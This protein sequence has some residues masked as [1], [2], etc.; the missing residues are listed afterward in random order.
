MSSVKHES[1]LD[2]LRRI[3]L[4]DENKTVQELKERVSSPEIRS[5]DVAEILPDALSRIT[6]E[7]RKKDLGRALSEPLEEAVKLSI[8]K[9]P[10]TFADLLY[11]VILPAIR[12][13]VSEMLRS[14][15]ERIDRAVSQRF[16]LQSLKWRLE[17]FRTGV[18]FSEILL[19]N[20]TIYSVEQA[21]LIHK[22]SGLL[23]QHSYTDDARH[24]DSDAVSGM[25]I[26]IERFV[27]DSFVENDEMLQR[28]TIGEHMV[29]LVDGPHAMLACVVRGMP[30]ASFVEDMREVLE[31]MHALEHDALKNFSGDKS[32]LDSLQP[33][34]EK[35]LHVEYKEQGGKDGQKYKRII[36]ATTA[37]LVLATLSGMGYWLFNKIQRNQVEAYV[38]GLNQQPGI[39]V[40]NYRKSGGEWWLE[41]LMDPSANRIEPVERSFFLDP[42]KVHLSLSAF[43]GMDNDVIL[44]RAREAL[45]VPESLQVTFDNGILSVSGNAPAHW[46]LNARNVQVLPPGVKHL[47]LSETI[48]EA[49]EVMAFLRQVLEPPESVTVSLF[50]NKI[51]YQG[52][53]SLDWIKSLHSLA[54]N[55]LGKISFDSASLISHEQ[56]RLVTLLNALNNRSIDFIDGTQL[57]QDAETELPGIAMTILE[58]DKLASM[59]GRTWQLR[60]VGQADDSGSEKINVPLRLKRAQTVREKLRRYGVPMNNIVTATHDQPAQKQVRFE[61]SL[62]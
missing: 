31:Q 51:Q 5:R 29:Y 19:R 15:V 26:A 58:I 8:R 62:Q 6:G 61:V 48:L 2:K 47:D 59:L 42:E 45:A 3:L 32:A 1:D 9:D 40:L 10:K 52:V 25:L 43:Q 13:A 60:I 54:E 16:S 27:Q 36:K 7:E 57:Q 35:C 38:A 39:R 22:D 34:L 17:S 12:R 55:F 41:G 30:P 56:Q 50:D 11:P 33:L 44:A 53:A 46:Y 4:G 14:F 21:L 24:T 37:I 23:I 28:V 18:P 49:E 20:T